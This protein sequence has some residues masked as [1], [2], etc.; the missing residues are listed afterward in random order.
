MVSAAMNPHFLHTLG[1]ILLPLACAVTLSAEPT[2]KAAQLIAQL[3]MQKIPVEGPW[4]ALTYR[5]TD[6][7][8]AAGLPAR[9]RGVPHV[10]GSAIYCLETK[11]DF[12]AFH[13]LQTDE[14][15][16]Y[17]GGDPL[18]LLLLHPDGHGET[19]ILGPDVLAGQHPQVTVPRGVWQG[20]RPIGA[21]ADSYTL[22]G[23]T[24]GPGFEYADCAFGY[25]DEL[26][27]QYPQF[28]VPI[29][30]LTR[31]DHATRPAADAKP[32]ATVP[33][34][35]P[36]VFI[37]ADV[38]AINAAPGIVLRE[39]AGRVAAAKSDDYSI[40]LFD[41]AAG[42]GMPTSYNQVSEEV[43]LIAR[44]SGEVT[45]DGKVTTVAAGA[46]VIIKPK[47]RHSI[48]A[49]AGEALSFYAISVP[50]YSPEDYVLSPDK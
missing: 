31:E 25:R 36:T 2:G 23:C 41:L 6:T 12:S 11:E 45:L 47:V 29:A 14:I 8:A 20:S 22:F 5:S 50:A 10:A 18:E 49:A 17:Y 4:F 42:Q 24:L 46:T 28:A 44:G 48:K 13:I 30:G 40:A 27:K 33:A 43:F 7:L 1:L 32:A 37:P 3:K 15:W 16:H 38:K 35:A 34:P 39:L 9:Y 19:V 26:Q 21:G